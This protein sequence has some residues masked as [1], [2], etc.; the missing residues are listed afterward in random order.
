VVINNGTGVNYADAFIY[1][2][3]STHILIMRRLLVNV[4]FHT[5]L[6]C[7]VPQFVW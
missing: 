2:K 4:L 3:P 7:F 1:F 5:L 6:L